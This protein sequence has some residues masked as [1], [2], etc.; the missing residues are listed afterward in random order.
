MGPDVQFMG[1]LV[2]TTLHADDAWITPIYY[3]QPQEEFVRKVEYALGGGGTLVGTYAGPS[4]RRDIWA[5]MIRLAEYVAGG[6]D[7][8][9]D[10]VVAQLRTLPLQ[11]HDMRRAAGLMGWV[12]WDAPDDC[13]PVH[14]SQR[15]GPVRSKSQ[16][17]RPNV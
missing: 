1:M 17:R 6:D 15:P 9:A 8:R 3:T 5:L 10:E 16:R 7:G 4:T 13:G 2:N 12:Q 14:P 11:G